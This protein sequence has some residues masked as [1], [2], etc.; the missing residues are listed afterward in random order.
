MIEEYLRLGQTKEN[1]SWF[2][3]TPIVASSVPQIFSKY[4][5]NILGQ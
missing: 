3:Y 4:Y 2:D 1:A 5:R